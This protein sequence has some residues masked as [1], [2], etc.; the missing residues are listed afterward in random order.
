[1][2]RVLALLLCLPLAG[3]GKFAAWR[4]YSRVAECYAAFLSISKYAQ[5]PDLGMNPAERYAQDRA[6]MEGINRLTPY[7]LKAEEAAGNS[8]KFL[9]LVIAWRRRPEFNI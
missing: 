1:M 2:N 7:T 5:D 8:S 9:R 6:T 4:D 3:C